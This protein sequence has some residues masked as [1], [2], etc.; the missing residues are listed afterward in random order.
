MVK[1]WILKNW[2]N[3]KWYWFI[4]DAFCHISKFDWIIDKDDIR[5]WLEIVYEEEE[6][7]NKRKQVWK[8]I[9]INLF[10]KSYI[11]CF[12]ANNLA[13]S[14]SLESFKKVS[15]DFKKIQSNSALRKVYDSYLDT[16]YNNVKIQ[17]WFARIWYQEKRQ[18]LPNG[19]LK[20]LTEVYDKLERNNEKFKDFL[21]VFVAYHKYFNPKAK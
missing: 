16:N 9:S 21:E 5:D 12:D 3:E 7:W 17:I 18:L 4:N 13:E 6:Q 10:M 1:K 8:I 2:N 20:F 19:F 14:L 15:E 11:D